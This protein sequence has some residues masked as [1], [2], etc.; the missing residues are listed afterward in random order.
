VTASAGKYCLHCP[1]YFGWIRCKLSFEP[2][3][4]PNI[5]LCLEDFVDLAVKSPKSDI[6]DKIQVP[7]RLGLRKFPS[8]NRFTVAFLPEG[9]TILAIANREKAKDIQKQRLEIVL[10]H[11]LF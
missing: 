6:F 11:N 4:S 7:R 5:P 8:W 1:P 9:L 10:R 3:E 2:G